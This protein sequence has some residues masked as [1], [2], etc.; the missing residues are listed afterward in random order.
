MNMGVGGR[1]PLEGCRVP[2]RLKDSKL[3]RKWIL[4][5]TFLDTA[6][7]LK[8]KRL[9]NDRL[10]FYVHFD[11]CELTLLYLILLVNKR[12]DEWVDQSRINFDKL[13]TS[14]NKKMS[15]DS[16]NV[17]LSQLAH[18]DSSIKLPITTE[19]NLENENVCTCISYVY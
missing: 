18:V 1:D 13:E 9:D 4:G 3:Y 5:L 2:V 19:D 16:S 6:E 17:S 14:S 7:I 10:E 12:L 11:D 15:R 8:V